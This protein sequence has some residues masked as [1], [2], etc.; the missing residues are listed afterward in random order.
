MQGWFWDSSTA[1]ICLDGV[2]CNQQLFSI[3]P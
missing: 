3:E 2:F 1:Y